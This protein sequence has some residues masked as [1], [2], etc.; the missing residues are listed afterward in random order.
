MKGFVFCLT[1]T[2]KKAWYLYSC[3]YFI[4]ILYL[5]QANMTARIWVFYAWAVITMNPVPVLHGRWIQLYT[6]IMT[7]RAALKSKYT[8]FFYIGSH[9]TSQSF[10]VCRWR[11]IGKKLKFVYFEGDVIEQKDLICLILSMYFR[12]YIVNVIVLS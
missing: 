11:K 4:L 7:C 5:Q 9:E 12:G 1:W 2:I 6:S 3:I 8:H 10:Y